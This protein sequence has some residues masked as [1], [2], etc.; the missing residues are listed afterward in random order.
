[1]GDGRGSGVRHVSSVDEHLMR[2][3]AREVWRRRWI[4]V[5]LGSA[6]LLAALALR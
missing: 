4:A 5:L 1:M 6:A 2:M 3:R